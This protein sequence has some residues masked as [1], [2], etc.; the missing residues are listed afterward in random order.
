MRL[1]TP[2]KI[3][4]KTAAGYHEL[5]PGGV[6]KAERSQYIIN[7]LSQ[8]RF[9][10]VLGNDHT[11]GDEILE[12]ASNFRNKNIPLKIYSRFFKEVFY[13]ASVWVSFHS[14]IKKEGL[15]I[16]NYDELEVLFSAEKEE[17]KLLNEAKKIFGGKIL[18]VK[19]GGGAFESR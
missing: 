12:L 17:Q 7:L 1:R 11:N 9:E 16:Y 8:G 14:G 18:S 5:A 2:V 3:T 13:C 6:F 10:V 19:E 15:E 4:L